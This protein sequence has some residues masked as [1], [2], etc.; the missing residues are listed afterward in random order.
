LPATPSAVIRRAKIFSRDEVPEV[1]PI[2]GRMRLNR[3]AGATI[4]VSVGVGLLTLAAWQH[5]RRD[6]GPFTPSRD[7][8]V[9]ERL[10]RSS[11]DPRGRTIR[12]L[13][14]TLAVNP[15]DA[16]LAAR[17]A[18]MEIED[19]RTTSDPRHLGYAQAALQVWWVAEDV[20]PEI[21]T[22]RATIRQSRHDFKGALADLDRAAA[23]APD[24]PQV[25]LTRSVVLSV[26]GRY[27]E[28]AQS[29]QP[30]WRLTAPIVAEV[31][32]SS[33]DGLTGKAPEAA[34]RLE[35]ALATISGGDA[36][37]PWA[38]SVLA[39]LTGWSGDREGA[40]R[41]SRAALALDPDDAYTRAQLAD[42]LI[43]LG[44]AEEVPE[45]LTGHETN[46]G[47]LLRLA[48]AE[49]TLGRSQAGAHVAEVAARFE[50]AR[51]RGDA[52]HGREEARFE[53]VIHHDARRAL[54]LAVA[55]WQV[56]HEPA[57]A[58]ILLEA[59]AAAREPAAA[60]AAVQWVRDTGFQDPTVKDLTAYLGTERVR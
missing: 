7:D 18:R 4:F 53:L 17:L 32:R 58:R 39:E 16:A 38:M 29:C 25:W 33:V 12:R 31:C 54:T 50:A 49:T 44:R 47:A 28:A 26:L 46:D 1:F 23:I 20:P 52:L 43:D 35:R 5:G 55:N 19:A 15:Y 45:L 57:D 8:E 24:E 2:P 3:A 9:V 56:Q 14:E 13:R 21:L 22:L 48:I 40:E 36:V 41:L 51:A 11:G 59:A 42:L 34:A 27:P 60:A 30:L 37:R 10:A 6:G